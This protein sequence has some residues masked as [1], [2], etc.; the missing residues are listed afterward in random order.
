[1]ELTTSADTLQQRHFHEAQ[2]A[3][4]ES[5]VE[6]PGVANLLLARTRGQSGQKAEKRPLADDR[7][8]KRKAKRKRRRLRSDGSSSDAPGSGDE[9]PAKVSE[10][11][12][13]DGQDRRL[14]SEAGRKAAMERNARDGGI[15]WNMMHVENVKGKVSNA[16]KG[17]T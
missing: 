8:S 10:E 1:M 2:D 17:F 12:L 16:N 15:S 7:R 5:D 11:H 4:T 13:E 3:D 9:Q 6:D 14:L